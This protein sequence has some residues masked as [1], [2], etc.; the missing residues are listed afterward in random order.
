MNLLDYQRDVASQFGEDGIIEQIFSIIKPTTKWC[1][2]FG[3]WDGKFASNTYNLIQNYDWSAVLIDGN[4]E[5]LKKAEETHKG[6]P[7]TLI[8]ALVGWGENDSLDAILSKTQIPLEFDFLS[9]DID[10]NDYHTWKALKRYRPKVVVIEF[11]PTFPD[12]ISYVQDADPHKVHGTSLKAMVE[13]GKEK[14]YELIC[15]NQEN[16]FFVEQKYFPLFGIA[17]NSIGTLKTYREPIQVAQLFDG[18]LV[19]F[20]SQH[21]FWYGIEFDLNRFQVL[22]AWVRRMNIPWNTPT[23]MRTLLL[24]LLRRWNRP[25]KPGPNAW[26]WKR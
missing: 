26:D 5:K 4:E 19:Y 23:R 14:G 17:D 10:G 15:V 18:T 16:A 1:V 8:P 12:N 2:E 9:I 20:G 24:R 6:K 11:N 25:A 3:A 13:L 21:L 22:P 7:V